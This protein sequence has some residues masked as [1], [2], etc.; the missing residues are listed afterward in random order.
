[1][2]SQPIILEVDKIRSTDGSS[3]VTISEIN[4]AQVNLVENDL[5]ISRN[6]GTD[7]IYHFGGTPSATLT[8]ASVDTNSLTSGSTLVWNGTEFVNSGLIIENF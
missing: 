6:D 5:G 4:Q 8:T 1:M 7:T 3:T 2:A